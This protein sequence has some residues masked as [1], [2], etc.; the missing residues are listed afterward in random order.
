MKARLWQAF[1][2]ADCALNIILYLVPMPGARLGS[3]RN[4]TL[5]RYWHR[6]EHRHGISWA[7][8]L[9]A[10]LSKID[11]EHCQKAAETYD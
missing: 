2:A 8:W 9:C 11:C 3:G 7:A 1:I 6:L 5:C 4:E 10:C